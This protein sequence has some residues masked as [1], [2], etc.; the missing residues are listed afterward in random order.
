MTTGRIN[1]V[2]SLN[3]A[4]NHNTVVGSNMLPANDRVV[5][6]QPSMMSE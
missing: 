1:Q 2:A 4:D 3:D 6:E 5:I